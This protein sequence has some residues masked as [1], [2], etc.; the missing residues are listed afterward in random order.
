[1]IDRL[2]DIL[3]LIPE[4]QIVID[5]YFIGV[6]ERLTCRM[7]FEVEFNNDLAIERRNLVLLEIIIKAINA[8]SYPDIYGYF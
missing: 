2:L 7:T 3:A 5:T 4:E 1:M 6:V 8:T